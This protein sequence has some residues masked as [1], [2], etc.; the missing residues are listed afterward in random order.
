MNKILVTG[1]T[2]HLGANLVRRLL[3][4]GQ[5]LRLLVRTSS[6]RQSL[7][8]LVGRVEL[9]EGDLRDAASVQ[10]AVAGCTRIYHTA[11][12]VS[13]LQGNA[14]L[15]RLI[16]DTNVLGTRHVLEAAQRHHV[17][18]VVVTSSL[19]AIGFDEAHSERPST[20]EAPF[21]PFHHTMPYE[22]SK[23][24]CEHECLRAVARGLDVRIATSCAI[25]GPHDY[26]PSRMGRALC[27][28]ANGKLAAYIPGGVEFV[29]AEDVC[30]GHVLAME[31]GR[32]GERYIFSTEHKTLPEIMELWEQITGVKK[33]TLKLPARLMGAIAAVTSPLLTWIA[34]NLPQRLTPDAIRILSLR[35]HVDLTKAKTELGYQ[36]TSVEAACRAAYAFFVHTGAITKPRR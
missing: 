16:F 11:A 5:D 4:D 33:P 3:A 27:D 32:P 36:P 21:Y 35:R 23:A 9:S 2:G 30:A 31:K 13:T 25:L 29:A 15:K 17:E 12:E 8:D 22:A 14:Q 6:D 19:G 10:R 34:P 24:F 28:F 18:R 7:A 20:E 1:A 26:K